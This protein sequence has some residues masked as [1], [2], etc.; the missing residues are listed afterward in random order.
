[1]E[2]LDNLNV[3][4]DVLEHLNEVEKSFGIEADIKSGSMLAP[5]QDKLDGIM[6]MRLEGIQ[7]I[8]EKLDS[9]I[10]TRSKGVESTM[11]VE[12]IVDNALVSEIVYAYEGREVDDDG[13]IDTL[14]PHERQEAKERGFSIGEIEH[15]ADWFNMI[16]NG[17]HEY[18]ETMEHYEVRFPGGLYVDSDGVTKDP[19]RESFR[20]Y[21]NRLNAEK[22]NLRGL[23]REVLSARSKLVS[24]LES[25]YK[26]LQMEITPPKKEAAKTKEAGVELGA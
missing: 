16:R 9:I 14:H 26:R 6:K 25:E 3:T 24:T 11:N 7:S 2:K 1:M 13:I 8:Q 10:D 22:G 4:P 19:C 20:H 18:K 21:S 12:E 23:E 5:D 17:G 15:I